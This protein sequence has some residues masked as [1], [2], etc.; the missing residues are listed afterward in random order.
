MKKNFVLCL[1]VLGLFCASDAVLAQANKNA[2]YTA[3][4]GV[5]AYT[6]RRS[7]PN[8]VEATLDSIKR[9]GFTEIEGSGGKMAPEEFKKLCNERGISIPSTGAGY[10][11]LVKDPAGVA[12]RTKALGATYLMCAWIP[13]EKGNFTLE[14][15]KKAVADFNAAGKVLKENGITFCYHTH[16]YE[17]QPYEKGTLLDY[18]IANTNPQY[19]SFEMDVLWT[20][21]GGGDPVALL[22]KYGNRWKLMHLKD[23]RKGT[24]KDLTGG[25]STDNDVALGTGEIDIPG[26]LREANKIGIKHFFI[27]DE[28][29]RV[30]EQ[31]PQTIAYLKSLKK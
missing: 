3:P 6:F 1:F 23:L 25:T 27:E 26:I 31:V 5:Q 30:N 10:E 2:L 11:E 8:G 24:P 17:F 28:S 19:V 9:F 7:F 18:I 20:H 21:F 14:N 22:K 15:A 13:H 4:F 29:N 16:G 12:A